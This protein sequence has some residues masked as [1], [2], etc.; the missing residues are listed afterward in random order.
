MID[1]A[2]FADAG[3]NVAEFKLL[4]RNQDGVL[5]AD[6]MAPEPDSFAPSELEDMLSNLEDQ[7]VAPSALVC[8]ACGACRLGLS[9]VVCGAC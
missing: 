4:D 8:G 5:D 7:L 9:V 6:E 1:Q 2:E 3:G